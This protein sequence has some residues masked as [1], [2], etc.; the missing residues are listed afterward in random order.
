[1]WNAADSSGSS[2]DGGAGDFL[3]VL[4]NSPNF[5]SFDSFG[6]MDPWLFYLE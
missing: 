3:E 2:R 5:D 1:M 6:K 4:I